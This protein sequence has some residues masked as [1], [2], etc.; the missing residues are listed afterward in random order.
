MF[1]MIL[2][3]CRMEL[4]QGEQVYHGF[5]GVGSTLKSS[6][7]ILLTHKNTLKN[8]LYLQY[9]PRQNLMFCGDMFG[10]STSF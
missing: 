10:F 4:R 7:S 6:L 9:N 1:C 8:I 5:S 3:A 2:Q